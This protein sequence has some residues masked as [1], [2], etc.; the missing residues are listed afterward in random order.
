[1]PHDARLH[2]LYVIT[3]AGLCTTR[4]IENCVAAALRGGARIVQY[5]DKSSDSDRRLQ[6]SRALVELCKRH[7][8]L[9]LVNDD[10]QLAQAA[11][12][13]GVHLGRDDAA[14][15]EARALL[16][17]AALI[18]YSCYD[19]FSRAERAAA[20]GANYVAFGSV[21][22]SRVKPDAVR[23]P[24]ALFEQARSRSHIPTCAIGGIDAG[25]ISDVVA[26]GANMAAVISAVFAA[27]DVAAAAGELSQAFRDPHPAPAR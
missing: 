27:N 16:G 22:E 12:A 19:D 20:A 17:G 14:V 1:M 23:A 25:N 13:H 4:G 6:E 8:A 9:L 11:G 7:D 10:V 15:S 3:D 21:F 24:L 2:G 26:A 5:R 18:G